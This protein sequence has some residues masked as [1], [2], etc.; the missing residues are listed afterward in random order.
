MLRHRWFARAFRL[1]TALGV[2]CSAA[3]CASFSSDAGMGAVNDIAGPTL[4]TDVVK[5]VTE[6]DAAAANARSARLLK[7]PLTAGGAVRLALLNN[8]GLQAAYN[9]LGIAE[10]VMVK[11]SLPPDLRFSLSGISTP[12][13]LEI[14]RRI[15][16]DIL[17]IAT[18]PARAEIASDRFRQAQL[19]AAVETLRVA[20]E[21]RR[22]Y[23]RA[24]AAQ[25]AVAA[26]KDAVSAANAA[27]ELAKE[28]V[29]TGAMNKLDQA[30]EE[31]FL[32]D[33]QIQLASARRTAAA[34]R[35]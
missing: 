23:Y 15:V 14:E 5:I 7:L 10:A 27:V 25:Q 21:V 19:R 24:V 8:R 16:A 6:E 30:R 12:V 32:A 17:A 20:M 33:L 11:A 1:G 26:L 4:K 35:E 31:A 29:A 9:D 18:L 28:L 34:A 2:A 13:E 22:S 3:A